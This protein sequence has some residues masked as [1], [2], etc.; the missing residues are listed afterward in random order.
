MLIVGLTGGMACGKTHVARELGRLGG[1]ILEADE[2]G[3]EV[4]RPGQAAYRGIVEAFGTEVL[5]GDGSINRAGLAAR[6]FGQ[7]A[8]L[9]RLNA[10]VHP[11][12]HAEEI[13]RMQEIAAKDPQAIVVRV[14]AILIESGAYRSADKIIVVTCTREQQ[15]ERALHRARL[16]DRGADGD[17]AAIVARLD[18]QMPLEKKKAFADYLIDASGTEDETLRQ[19]RRIWEDLKRQV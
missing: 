19:A 15:I 5:N 10:I 18:S 9:E 3:H 8:E 16:S 6:V 4:M 7:P 13:R 1:Y 14:A 17:A 2:I 11:A 12:V